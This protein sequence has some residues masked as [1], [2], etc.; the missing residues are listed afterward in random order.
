MSTGQRN[1]TASMTTTPRLSIGLPVHNGAKYLEAALDALLGQSY[2]DFELIISDNASSDA[3]SDIGRR[4]ASQ[5]SRVR[6]H[7][8]PKN[9]GCS[10]NHNFVLEMA[11]GELFKWASYD[12][13]Y[14]RDLLAS[15]VAQ[16]DEDPEAVLAHSWS[17]TI[18]TTDAVTRT[19]AYSLSTGVRSPAER[20]RSLLFDDGGDD[21]YGVVRTSILRRLTPY[22]SFHH[23]DRTIVAEL[24]LHGPFRQV[25]DWLF[26][27]RDH[28]DQAARACSAMRARCANLDPRRANRLR[29]PAARLYGEYLW[30]FIAAI[31]NAP[32]SSIERRRCYAH[33]AT[34]TASRVR[35]R[36]GH[37]APH[38]S[39]PE[40]ARVSVDAVVARREATAGRVA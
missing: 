5:D 11:R 17:A 3:T 14:A 2:R 20:F 28:P 8:Q 32:L 4:Y 24:S 26:F 16:L 30:S 13:L 36:A 29:H 39:E 15:C 33:L 12:D 34:W 21:I 35:R 23:A 27:R 6:Y 18:D 38:I 22:D 10:P 7:R 9:I 40:I 37:H 1:K 25:P 19:P 31:R